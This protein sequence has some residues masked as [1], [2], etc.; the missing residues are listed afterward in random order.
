M[1]SAVLRGIVAIVAMLTVSACGAP[2]DE[3]TMEPSDQ[4]E[5]T[6]AAPAPV[7]ADGCKGRSYADCGNGTCGKN[8]IACAWGGGAG[9]SCPEVAS[10]PGT[11]AA[12]ASQSP[13][14]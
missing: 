14:D 1:K 11:P 12:L 10:T 9:C 2:A 8:N 6:A 5:Q 7:P 13:C 4:V 3:A